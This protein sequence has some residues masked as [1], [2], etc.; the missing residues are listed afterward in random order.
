MKGLSAIPFPNTPDNLPG[1]GTP[2]NQG[3]SFVPS[4]LRNLKLDDLL[5][6]VVIILLLTDN[7]C[8][9]KLLIGIL[10]LIFI[11]GL[12]LSLFDR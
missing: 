9:D 11:S 4:F 1:H 5:L 3:H 6:L 2:G 8:D 10:I 12:D 7:N